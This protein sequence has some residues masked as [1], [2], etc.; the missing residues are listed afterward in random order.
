MPLPIGRR[1]HW[2]SRRR[3]RSR[4]RIRAPA[5]ITGTRS[6]AIRA[7][8]ILSAQTLASPALPRF[9]AIWQQYPIRASMTATA[10]R[11][12]ITSSTT[13]MPA[14]YPP[15][16]RRHWDPRCFASRPKPF[17]RAEKYKVRNFVSTAWEARNATSHLSLP[18]QD[19]EALRYLD[20]IHELLRA[21]KAPSAEIA[22]A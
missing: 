9:K 1:A 7:A 12:P 3:T 6:R 21:V 4:T 16:S 5:L 8:R 2:R 14:F 20:A 11:A 15:A 13:T 17:P 19:H 18:L 22:E 10:N